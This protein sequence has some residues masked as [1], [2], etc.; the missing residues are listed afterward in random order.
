M[1]DDPFFRGDKFQRLLRK[2][3][4]FPADGS[5]TRIVYMVVRTVTVND[6]SPLS[7]YSRCVDVASTFGDDYRKTKVMS[8]K[9]AW[10]GVE[11]NYIFF[12]NLSLNLPINLNVAHL[13]G[14]TPSHLKARKRLFWRGDI[15][16]M[17]VQLDSESSFIVKECLNANRLDL[18]S[19]EQFLLEKYRNGNLESDLYALEQECKPN[20]GH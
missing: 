2:C 5:E 13:L 8:N 12:Y 1:S 18:N 11:S 15:V 19:L 17:K 16:A 20:S 14:V 4:V 9:N 3:V 7:S 6:I 10:D